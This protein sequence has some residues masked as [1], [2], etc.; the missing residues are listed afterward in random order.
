MPDFH[1]G[2]FPTGFLG[3]DSGFVSFAVTPVV[4]AYNLHVTV[5]GPT[6]GVNVATFDAPATLTSAVPLPA[7]AAPVVSPVGVTTTA[8]CTGLWW[9]AVLVAPAPAGV[10][11]Q[12]LYV[13]D[14][15][16]TTP[17]FYTINVGAAGGTFVLSPTSGPKDAAGGSTAPF[18]GGDN[19]YA[20][21]V[22]SD[23]DIL[24]AAPPN[25]TQQMPAL[26]AQA[27]VVVGPIFAMT[28]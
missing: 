16:G 26:P 15:S 18:S 27:D 20:Y 25:N 12:I 1:N 9:R 10:T 3:Y 22:G 11:N 28:Y 13:V 14:V 7:E 2:T 4:G 17:T 24:A 21:V 8:S 23:Y 19:V 6:I 5:P